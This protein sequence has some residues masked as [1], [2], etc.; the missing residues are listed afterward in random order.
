[1]MHQNRA[2]PHSFRFVS[3]YECLPNHSRPLRLVSGAAAVQS[4]H[5][6]ARG[7]RQTGGTVRAQPRARRLAEVQQAPG[8]SGIHGPVF[9]GPG[10]APGPTCMMRSTTPRK[11]AALMPYRRLLAGIRQ[12]RN[13]NGLK[14]VAIANCLGRRQSCVAQCAK[15][16]RLGSYGGSLRSGLSPLVREML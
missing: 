5:A 16:G 11:Q 15:G 4:A 8:T 6:S 10:V 1:M 3:R 13:E 14:Q 9:Q 7:R 12:A 2:G